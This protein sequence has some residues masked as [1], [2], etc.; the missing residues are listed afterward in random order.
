VLFG[1]HLSIFYNLLFYTCCSLYSSGQ[2]SWLQ[3]QRFGFDARRYQIFL[4]SSGSGTGSTQPREDN[5][6]A[7]T[8]KYRLRSRKSKLTTVGDSLSW[9]RDT[10]C[11]LKLALTSPTSGGRSVGIVRACGLKPRSFL[12]L[13][14]LSSV[15][16]SVL[17]SQELTYQSPVPTF[18]PSLHPSEWKSQILKWKILLHSD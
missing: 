1:C 10:L 17:L 3:I 6:G 14:L 11:L 5:W 12:F 15:A 4:R 2:S 16:F 9:P 18:Y 7:I 8:R 13:Y